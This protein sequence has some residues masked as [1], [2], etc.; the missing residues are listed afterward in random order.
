MKQIKDIDYI[1]L[2]T[3]IKAMERGLLSQERIERMLDAPTVEEAAK[4]LTECGYSEMEEITANE[5]E[6]VLG[7][8][9]QKVMSDLS[10]GAPDRNLVD[11]FKL[12]Y[13]YHNAKVLVKAEALE[14]EQ[15]QLLQGG[16]RYDPEALATDFRRE[17]LSRCTDWFRRGIARAREILGSTGDPQQADFILDRAYFEEMSA[18][19]ADTDSKFLRDYVALAIDVAN[20]RSC[21]R[22]ARLGKGADFLNQVLVNGGSVS[23][24]NLAM[25][26]GDE[27]GN[28]FRLGSLSEAAAE[29]ASKSAPGSGSLNEFERL[30]DNAVMSFLSDGRRVPFGAEPIIGYIFAREAETT[31]IRTI[32]SGRMA[33]LDG[34]T[35]RQRLRR[36]YC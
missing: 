14:T 7:E 17:D 12:R 16:G 21:V 27:L 6:R 19:A 18:I 36:T 2:S 34:N 8:Q 9:Q 4:V 25:A 3:R 32:I 28:L 20:L 33:G 13:D 10:S 11:I 1:F 31:A 24:R 22:A 15:D 29:G 5:L 30:C 26:R 35:I 23:V